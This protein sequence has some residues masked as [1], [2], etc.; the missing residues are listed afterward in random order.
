M[1]RLE[2]KDENLD[3]GFQDLRGFL[4]LTRVH[5]RLSAS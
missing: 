5:Q 4:F 3:A 2:S 1:E